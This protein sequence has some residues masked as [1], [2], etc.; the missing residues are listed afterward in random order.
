MNQFAK[1]SWIQSVLNYCL[2]SFLLYTMWCNDQQCCLTKPLPET[3]GLLLESYI[4]FIEQLSYLTLMKNVVMLVPR[5]CLFILKQKKT[6]LRQPKLELLLPHSFSL[7]LFVFYFL[8]LFLVPSVSSIFFNVKKNQ[9]V[10]LQYMT[11]F[12][13]LFLFVFYGFIAT[14]F[15]HVEVLQHAM[16]LVTNFDFQ[17]KVYFY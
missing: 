13:I 2:S 4:H 15:L 6:G 3:N 17:V 14:C 9:A 7:R 12:G 16:H 5:F 1:M 10:Y 11:F 8:S